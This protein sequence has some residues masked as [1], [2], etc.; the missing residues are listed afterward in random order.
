MHAT[1]A[2]NLQA[3]VNFMRLW[4]F[5][6]NHGLNIEL[7]NHVVNRQNSWCWSCH[8]QLLILLLCLLK[9]LLFAMSD[10]MAGCL[11]GEVWRFVPVLNISHACL[12]SVV[13]ISLVTCII[14]STNVT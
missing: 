11:D 5:E 14:K 9:P 6:L 13:L 8:N 7:S 4:T 3:N 12:L 2:H 1:S 10:F